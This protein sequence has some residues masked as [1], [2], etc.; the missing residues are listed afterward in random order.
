[1]FAPLF[2]AS[3]GL[4]ACSQSPYENVQSVQQHVVGGV[5]SP[6][7]QNAVVH[8]TNVGDRYW[9]TGVVV[10]PTLIL[11]ARQNLFEATTGLTVYLRCITPSSGT[12]V[13]RGLDLARF[14]VE[15][16]NGPDLVPGPSIERVY[17]GPDLD[18]CADALA[19]VKVSRPLSVDP[20]AL[21]LNG[22]AL[23]GEAG[24]LVGWGA[25]EAAPG[26]SPSKQ[27][28][29]RSVDVDETSDFAFKAGEGA[30]SGDLGGPF[31]SSQT[32]AVVGILTSLDPEDHGD[33]PLHPTIDD[34]RTAHPIFQT[35]MSDREWLRTAFADAHEAPWLEDFEPPAGLAHACRAGV[36]CISGSCVHAGNAGFCSQPCDTR[37]CP[38]GLECVG[39]G[40][41]RVCA[42]A[43][44]SDPGTP[45]QGCAVAPRATPQSAYWIAFVLIPAGYL[46]GRRQRRRCVHNR[47]FGQPAGGINNET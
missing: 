18:F 41:A 20:L 11:T 34:C 15:L 21:R 40:G 47:T 12:P 13:G 39:L 26:P 35:V 19:L 46:T 27:R 9:F 28:M 29:Q 38:E 4:F 32:G 22:T 23:S 45:S 10:A 16:G 43:Q 17:A 24:T 14:S 7:D 2:G 37:A 1:M 36:E 3:F 30:C 8:L 25:T 44:L 42:P 31:I 5:A 6:S 33:I